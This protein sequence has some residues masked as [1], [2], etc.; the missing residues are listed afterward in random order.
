MN[1]RDPMPLSSALVAQRLEELR[2]LLRLAQS[3][4]RARRAEPYAAPLPEGRP[5]AVEVPGH[6]ASRTLR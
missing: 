1:T 4:H 5:Q 6:A 2:A 3:L